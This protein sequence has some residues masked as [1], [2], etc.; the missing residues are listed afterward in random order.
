MKSTSRPTDLEIYQTVK[1]SMETVRE[2]I[3]AAVS[4]LEQSWSCPVPDALRAALELPSPLDD[5]K[6][7]PVLA[8]ARAVG[9]QYLL[10]LDQRSFPHGAN[11]RGMVFWHPDTFLTAFF[12]ADPDAY[13]DV[14]LDLA[15]VP[16][17]L[18]LFPS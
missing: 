6:D 3:D 16:A 15:D 7:W 18:P 2:R 12:L 5:E 1:D 11:W 9:V 14:A 4:A 13:V 10:S 8:A 17:P